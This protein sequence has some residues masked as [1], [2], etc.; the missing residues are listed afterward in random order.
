MATNRG[1]L[2]AS[3]NEKGNKIRSF[4]ALL[5]QW[6]G[7]FWRGQSH[8]GK[9]DA[10]VARVPEEAPRQP[11]GQIFARDGHHE[12][13]VVDLGG[14]ISD[15]LRASWDDARPFAPGG[16]IDSVW[17]QPLFAAGS[18]A[19][20]S[21]AAGNVFLATANP[22][23][24][25]VIRDGLASA[26]IGEGGRIIGH[27]PF[28]AAGSAIVPVVAPVMLFTAVSSLITGTRLDRMQ[29]TLGTL[30]EVLA[31][32][33]HLKETEAYA[34]YQSA[35]EQLD[36]I[37]SQY[38]HSQRFTDAMKVALELARGNLSLL[39]YQFEHLTN[40][41]IRSEN[42]VRTAMADIHLYFLS[43]L[44]DIR[45]D[46]LR[47]YLTLQDDPGYAEHR[48]AALG[49]KVEQRIG[50]FKELLDDDPIEG[51]FDEQGRRPPKGAFYDPRTW[52]ATRPDFEAMRET[53]EPIRQRMERWT[54]AFDSA[55]DS[56]YQQSIVV[57]RDLDGERTLHA[58]HTQDLS[59]RRVG[60]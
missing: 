2:L 35:T 18:T 16:V 56:A 47:L 36:G 33:R 43:S 20:S 17:L 14:D 60:A 42:D 15:A 26:I 48:Q 31:R 58:Q 30:S 4:V 6:L 38:E 39:R 32:I 24:L 45:A 8:P 5:K 23:T 41:K 52:F 10:V 34:K 12:I 7:H 37:W 25:M 54:G 46:L 29:R 21:L 59:L 49:R 27:A 22:E 50:I 3:M 44:M 11:V 19:A 9:K 57:Y 1:E 28:V 13:A 51:F 40:R 55:T 53:Y